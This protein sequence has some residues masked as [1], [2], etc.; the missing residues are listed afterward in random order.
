MNVVYEPWENYHLKLC[1]PRCKTV[2]LF[3]ASI[4]VILACALVNARYYI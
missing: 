4:G 3:L 2:L 1:N